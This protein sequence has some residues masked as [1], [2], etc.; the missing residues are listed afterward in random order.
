MKNIEQN[1]SI[2]HEKNLIDNQIKRKKLLERISDRN[3]NILII[4]G[5][6]IAI[7]WFNFNSI[8]NFVEHASLGKYTFYLIIGGIAM[9]ILSKLDYRL[10]KEPRIRRVILVGSIGVL[11]FMLLGRYFLP[12]VV[13]K[14]GGAYAW[15]RLGPISIQPAEL[16]KIVF[17]TLIAFMLGEGEKKNI[18]FNVRLINT[19]IIVIVFG[20]FI[21]LQRDL[22][23]VIHYIIIALVM[24]FLSG[25]SKK[26][27]ISLATPLILFG[28]GACYYIYNYGDV[29]NGGYKLRRISMYLEGLFGKGYEG[30]LDIGYQVN[31]SLLAFGNGGFFGVGYGNGV[32]K[33]SYLPEI[34]T[35]FIMAVLAEEFGFFGIIVVMILFLVLYSLIMEVALESKDR[36]GKYVAIGIGGL[37]LTQVFIN[38]FVAVG[39]LPVFGIP[40]PIFSYGGSSILT[41]MMGLGIVLSVNNKTISEFDKGQV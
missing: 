28:S 37:I 35:D 24:I 38:T 16:L 33:Y 40:M 26:I 14:I 21:A 20:G 29:E 3:K 19:I 30:N 11:L 5:L 12:S 2:Y 13:R 10:L 17:I 7:A 23:T 1:S 6:L 18:H 8:S 25:F 34:H 39:L 22:G 36:F 32:Q 9:K 41:I 15:I 4:T 31:Q 27:I